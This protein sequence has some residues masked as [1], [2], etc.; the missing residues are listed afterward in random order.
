[1]SSQFA[2]PGSAWLGVDWGKGRGGNIFNYMHL[3][4]FLGAEV[5]KITFKPFKI[6]PLPLNQNKLND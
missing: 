4:Q 3:V 6:P 1:M 5:T 2:C